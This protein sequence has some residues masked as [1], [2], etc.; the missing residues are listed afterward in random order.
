MSHFFI[1]DLD[2]SHAMACDALRRRQD[3]AVGGA[4][5]DNRHGGF[6]NY[7]NF[8][9]D[10][11]R[12]WGVFRNQ[13]LVDMLSVAVSHDVSHDVILMTDFYADPR[14]R[15]LASSRRLIE[16][17]HRFLQSFVRPVVVLGV[18]NRYR[19]LEPLV[20][21]G[22]HFGFLFKTPQTLKTVAIECAA[23]L[24]RPPPMGSTVVRLCDIGGLQVLQ[25]E[26][27]LRSQ[28][29]RGLTWPPT[30]GLLERIK[31]ID[32]EALFYSLKSDFSAGSWLM[33]SE[34][35]ARSYNSTI[36]QALA[37]S[38]VIMSNVS[39]DEKIGEI[40]VHVDSWKC[41]EPSICV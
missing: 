39:D 16:H 31:R 35:N 21:I 24:Q 2:E 18:E 34:Q 41:I 5:L 11:H 4:P 26:H 1:A 37:H 14:H 3:D 29:D 25:L 12:H 36:G 33:F 23:S 20:E 38:N 15:S 13:E 10:E 7:F 28:F 19:Y 22:R 27:M 6:F 30:E 32:P 40:Q 9:A 8:I 17:M